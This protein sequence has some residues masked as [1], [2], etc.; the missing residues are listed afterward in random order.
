MSSFFLALY[1]HCQ[2][3]ECRK[4]VKPFLTLKIERC[5]YVKYTVQMFMRYL[6]IYNATHCT[7]YRFF[8]KNPKHTCIR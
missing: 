8:F 7:Q 6:N 4:S 2:N 1:H 5:M 3:Y